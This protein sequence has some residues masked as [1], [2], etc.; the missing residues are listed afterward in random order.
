LPEDEKRIFH[1][2][3]N[4]DEWC[5]AFAKEKNS[6]PQQIKTLFETVNQIIGVLRRKNRDIQ[7]TIV[8]VDESD[9]IFIDKAL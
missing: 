5:N 3:L 8:I 2:I 7:Q 4:N 1:Y 9:N 6:N